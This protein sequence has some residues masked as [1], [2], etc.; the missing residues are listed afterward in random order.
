LRRERRRGDAREQ[1]RIAHRRYIDIGM[2]GFAE[3]ARRE[4]MATGETVRKRSPDTRDNLT[5]QESQIAR[6]A[7]EGCTNVEIGAQLFI[8]PRTVEWHLRG[9]FTKLGIHS[10]KELSATALDPRTGAPATETPVG[11]AAGA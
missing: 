3:R 8:S 4:L 2:N 6:L 10:R 11:T 1:L 9:V 7:A 5:A